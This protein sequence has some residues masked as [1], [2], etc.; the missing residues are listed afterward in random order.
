MEVVLDAGAGVVRDFVHPENDDEV[1]VP[2][3]PLER[4][5]EVVAEDEPG[6]DRFPAARHWLFYAV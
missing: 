2:G 5:G 6:V 3:E 1:T 4:R